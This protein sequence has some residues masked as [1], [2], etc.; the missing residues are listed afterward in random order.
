MK[1]ISILGATGSIGES[2]IDVIVDQPE[3]FKVVALT[4]NRNVKK[5]ADLAIRMEAEMAVIRDEKLLPELKDLLA[6]RGV[7]V[8]CGEA[9]LIEAAQTDCNLVVAGIV[10]MA[11]LPPILA[12]LEKGTD[13]A[14]ANKEPLVSAGP[15]VIEAAERS[16]AKILPVDSEHNA[17]FQV[18]E[19]NNRDAVRRLILTA[20][21]GP[22]LNFSQTDLAGVTPQMAVKHPNWSMGKKISVDSATMM[23]KALEVVEAHYLFDMPVNKIDVLVHPQSIIHSM[24]EYADGSVLAQMGDPDM[25]TSIA[26][27]MGWPERIRSPARRLDFTLAPNLF[28]EA[29]DPFKFPALE[30]G[31]SALRKGSYA[32]NALNAANEVAV[33]AFLEGKIS[34]LQIVDIVSSVTDKV[35]RQKLKTLED[36]LSF[37]REARLQALNLIKKKAA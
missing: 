16:G 5:L 36:V 8:A 32:C 26:H 9:G 6:G 7:D 27:A 2:T 20:S 10:G 19:N 22:F 18:F 13:V 37:D 29:V 12:A 21:G 17:I 28:F 30:M 31:Y 23:N 25:R 33:E 34:Y 35:K 24:V 11:G 14:I 15:L 1:K 3:K 4:A